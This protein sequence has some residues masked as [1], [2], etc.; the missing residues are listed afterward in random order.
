M[1]GRIVL[2]GDLEVDHKTVERWVQILENLYLCFRV[3]PF[4]G[5]RIRAVKKERKLYLWD[6]SMVEE[7]GPRFENLVASQLLK[8]CHSV[9]DTE[10]WPLELRYLRDTDRREVDFVVLRKRKP[11]FAV[12]CKTGERTAAPALSYFAERTGIPRFFQV[13]LGDAHHEHGKITV[14]PFARL[15]EELA[16]P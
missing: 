12:E 10:G 14:L 3:P 4:G 9:E 1:F 8:Y 7:P 5:P 11:I 15:C 6:W 16:L 13:H 2:S